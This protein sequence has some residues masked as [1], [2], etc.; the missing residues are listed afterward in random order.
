[1]YSHLLSRTEG[2]PIEKNVSIS[3][4]DSQAVNGPVG[5]AYNGCNYFL[6]GQ[7]HEYKDVTD[8]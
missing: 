1:M 6:N 8:K 3:L 5:L 4:V 7:Q 2:F